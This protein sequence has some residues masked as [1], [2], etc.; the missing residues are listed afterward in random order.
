MTSHLQPV[1]HID[2]ISANWI[3]AALQRDGLSGVVSEVSSK[4][5][6]TGQMADSF[7]INLGFASVDA[8]HDM[9]QSVVVK[10]QAEDELSRQAGAGGA[11]SSEM[12][13]YTELASTVSIRTPHCYFAIGPDDEGRFA[14]V[15][16][17]MAPAEQGDQLLGCDFESARSAVI[18]L[19]GLH[20]PRWCDP[21]LVDVVPYRSAE[22]TAFLASVVAESTAGFIAHYGDR[23]DAEDVLV[24][25]AFAP[26]CGKWLVDNRDRFAPVHGDYRLDNLL[27]GKSDDGGVEVSA[28]D[29]QTLDLGL[30]GRDLGYFLGNSLLPG[31][32]RASEKELVSAY[33]NALL[34]HG[35]EDYSLEQC[36]DDYRYGQFQGLMIT[37]LAAVGLAHTE[38]GDD[39][40]MAMSSRACEAIR[41]LDSLA[42]LER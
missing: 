8:S 23:V 41:D 36:F 17:D 20:G 26:K 34:G 22:E 30:P 13:F 12:R 29:W 40:F 9:P 3:T 38:R 10:M 2:D 25:Q 16:E 39:M 6:G 24:L 33:Y 14:L 21:T 18:N 32:R 28:V 1:E 5:I 31:D 11:Y 42:L 27:F 15:L 19:A 4:P 7:R 35:V 37:V